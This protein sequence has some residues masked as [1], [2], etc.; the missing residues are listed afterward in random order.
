[1]SEFTT[2]MKRLLSIAAFLLFAIMFITQVT[3]EETGAPMDLD[4]PADTKSLDMELDDT[5]T[6]DFKTRSI[7][8]KKRWQLDNGDIDSE[9]QIPSL[10]ESDRD[11]SYSGFRLRRPRKY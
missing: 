9:A 7:G 5:G 2:L 10:K 8:R 11:S 1:M 3:A 6:S 4:L